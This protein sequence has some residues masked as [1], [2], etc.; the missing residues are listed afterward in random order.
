VAA[1]RTLLPVQWRFPL[2][3]A[4][5]LRSASVIAVH[6]L[7]VEWSSRNFMKMS[8]KFE[9]RAPV[10]SSTQL[11]NPRPWPSSCITTATKS[12]LPLVGL[13]SSP[14]YQ[15][16]DVRQPLV[17]ILP[18]NCATMSLVLESRSLPLILFANACG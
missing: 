4:D 13:P 18:L 15:P 6:I 7:L 11:W 10:V 16:L 8:S 3:M 5:A 2:L 14:K 17:P 9:A 12:I 1:V